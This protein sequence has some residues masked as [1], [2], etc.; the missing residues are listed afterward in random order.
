MEKGGFYVSLFFSAK[1][2]RLMRENPELASIIE[3]AICS[4]VS[5]DEYQEKIEEL[6]NQIRELRSILRNN[7]IKIP[8]PLAVAAP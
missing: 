6:Q 8:T 4:S 3:D 5:Y 1:W 7:G 2:K